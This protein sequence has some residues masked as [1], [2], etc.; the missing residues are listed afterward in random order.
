VGLDKAL[1]IEEKEGGKK[2]KMKGKGMEKR[3]TKQ[4][5]PSSSF[6]GGKKVNK[7]AEIVKKVNKRAE[8]VKR[9]MKDRNVSMI[10]ASKIVKSEGLY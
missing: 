4:D 9:V 6:S 10:Q 3:P 8:I 7:R 5:M 1:G 2:R